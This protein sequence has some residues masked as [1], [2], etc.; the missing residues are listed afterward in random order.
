MLPAV[1][2]KEGA[3]KGQPEIMELQP[4]G[5]TNLRMTEMPLID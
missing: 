5:C 1:M 4:Y 2:K 3:Q